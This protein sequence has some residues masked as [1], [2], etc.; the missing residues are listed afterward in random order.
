[1]GTIP[2]TIEDDG[3]EIWAYRISG[4]LEY[5]YLQIKFPGTDWIRMR[6]HITMPNTNST[7][8]FLG[9]TANMEGYLNMLPIF[10]EHPGLF[11]SVQNG[12]P[13]L[14]R[15]RLNARIDEGPDQDMYS[16]IDTM[17]LPAATQEDIAAYEYLKEHVT[18]IRTWSYLNNSQKET[19]E[20]CQY[21]I[22]HYPTTI[23]A[24]IAKYRAM[25]IIAT[26]I[27]LSKPP[28]SQEKVF[29]WT[30]ENCLL[31]KYS[32]SD[33]VAAEAKRW[34]SFYNID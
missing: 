32:K 17:Y 15:Y 34:L 11:E 33:L 20:T 21:L 9:T 25:D 28:Q 4:L 14:I 3:D 6:K 2:V 10:D 23:I 12:A 18:N 30:K 5:S 24:E 8:G 13:L 31:F 19:L 22:T 29:E 26:D 16:N 1:M 27:D 7:R